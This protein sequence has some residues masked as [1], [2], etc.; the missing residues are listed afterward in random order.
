MLTEAT[1]KSGART[2]LGLARRN[3]T[4]VA[5]VLTAESRFSVTNVSCLYTDVW[6][7]L[8]TAIV[9]NNALTSGTS[10]S[11]ATIKDAFKPAVGTAGGMYSGIDADVYVDLNGIIHV[12]PRVNIN[13]NATLYI[14]V[15]MYFLP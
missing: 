8:R 11:V 5:N 13:A 15:P 10:Y 9:T 7:Q 14:S 6:A 12:V 4:T 1:T 2:N 3:E